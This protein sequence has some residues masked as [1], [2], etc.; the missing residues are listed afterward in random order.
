MSERN[1]IIVASI[2]GA[3]GSGMVAYLALTERGREVRSRLE[4]WTEGT[5]REVGYVSRIAQQIQ[6]IAASSAQEWERWRETPKH[7]GST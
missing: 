3:I 2:V 6:R 7:S 5:M 4:R 1:I